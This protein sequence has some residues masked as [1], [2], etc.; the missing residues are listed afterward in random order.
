VIVSGAPQEILAEHLGHLGLDDLEV[1]G[2]TLTVDGDGRY[3]G[4]VASNVG[5][6]AAKQELIGQ[7]AR[8]TGAVVLGVGDS[9]SDLPLLR[10]ARRQLIVGRHA[11]RLL[12][13][14]G[15]SAACVPDP[16]TASTE[17][18]IDLVSVLTGS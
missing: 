16:A 6:D 13:E 9:T 2:L 17:E 1:H 5:T 3:A 7:L 8:S 15:P 11:R 4:A 10:A 12:E 14:F 18:M